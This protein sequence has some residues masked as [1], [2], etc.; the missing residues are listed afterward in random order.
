MYGI[1]LYRV[2]DNYNKECQ[3]ISKSHVLEDDEILIF[4][5]LTRDNHSLKDYLP[6][7]RVF[8]LYPD[9][10]ARLMPEDKIWDIHKRDVRFYLPYYEVDAIQGIIFTTDNYASADDLEYLRNTILKGVFQDTVVLDIGANIGNHSLYFAKECGAKKIYSFEP[11][12]ETFRI[13]Q[14]NVE[15]NDLSEVITPVNAGV[16][17][18]NTRAGIQS[19]ME[20]D[21]GKSIIEYKDEGEINVVSLDQMGIN[22]KVGFIKIDVEG[23]ELEVFKGAEKLIRRDKPIIFCEIWPSYFIEHFEEISRILQ[24]LGYECIAN[25]SDYLFVQD[26]SD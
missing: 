22:E 13:L 15:I 3:T 17:A 7:G 6:L 1:K 5:V 25:D 8:E 9:K 24:P 23:F 26:S 2:Y 16:G 4:S 14:K 20:E 21:F 19:F 11:V 10:D 18:K 12:P